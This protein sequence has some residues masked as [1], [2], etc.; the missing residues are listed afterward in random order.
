MNDNPPKVQS[1]FTTGSANIFADLGVPNAD[2]ELAELVFA[3]RSHIRQRNLSQKEAAKLLHTDQASI[4]NEWQS[5]RL[6]LRMPTTR[7]K[8]HTQNDGILNTLGILKQQSPVG[9]PGAAAIRSSSCI[10][11]TLTLPLP[12]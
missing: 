9:P 5:W 11:L 7:K 6:R 3:I 8:V 12:A 10:S 1:E 4:R 2:V